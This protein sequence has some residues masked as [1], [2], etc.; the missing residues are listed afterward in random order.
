MPRKPAD[1]KIRAQAVRRLNSGEK[2]RSIASDL[3]ISATAVRN[4]AR[5]DTGARPDEPA[6]LPAPTF[7]RNTVH[8]AAPPALSEPQE[9]DGETFA[10]AAT[11][12]ADDGDMS[13][14]SASPGAPPPS[15]ATPPETVVDLFEGA[16]G[17]C[18]RLVVV[19]R[20]GEWTDELERA[21][22]FTPGERNRLLV[23]A[24]YVAEYVGTALRSSPYVGIALFGMSALE[25]ITSRLALV[26]RNTMRPRLAR[27]AGAPPEPERSPQ[28]APE[29]DIVEPMP[30]SASPGVA[31][32][33]W[34]A[35]LGE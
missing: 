33:A 7:E 27:A 29:P 16:V 11:A 2:A 14:A 15:N 10:A 28:P 12:A 21:C 4:W 18:I 30:Q 3:G 20:G 32:V 26:K 25:V 35:S 8:D 17:L 13:S 23:T 22:R 5:A 24:P 9:L 1:P 19:G 6:T 31:P 34:R